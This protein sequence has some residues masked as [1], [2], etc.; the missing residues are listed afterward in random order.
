MT[1]CILVDRF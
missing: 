1:P